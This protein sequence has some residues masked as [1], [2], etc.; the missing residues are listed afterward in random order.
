M[1]L[2]SIWFD[3]CEET[4]LYASRTVAYVTAVERGKTQMRIWE[5]ATLKSYLENGGRTSNREVY[6]RIGQFVHLGASHL[7]PTAYGGRPAYEHAVRS[8]IANL[9]QEGFLRKVQR[10]LHELTAK[11]KARA[12]SA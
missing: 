7:A 10:G 1:V 5:D 8:Y 3:G 11:G 4:C 12:S 2:V 6:E 9:C